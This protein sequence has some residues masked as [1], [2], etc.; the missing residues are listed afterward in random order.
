MSALPELLYSLGIPA[1]IATVIIVG[2]LICDRLLKYLDDGAAARAQQSDR[3]RLSTDQDNLRRAMLSQVDQ[4]RVQAALHGVALDATACRLYH[5]HRIAGIQVTIARLPAL[6][7][8]RRRSR[9]GAY[10]DQGHQMGWDLSDA[11]A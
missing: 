3:E 1:G 4:L 8:T 7:P 11:T 9:S 10:Q 5:E 6:S 2:A